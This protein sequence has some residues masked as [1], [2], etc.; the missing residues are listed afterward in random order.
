MVLYCGED[1]GCDDDDDDC[2]DDCC[3]DVT[4]EG[5][6]EKT[7]LDPKG[8][9]YAIKR[10]L[11]KYGFFDSLT[12]SAEDKKRSE[13]YVSDK[14]RQTLSENAS[15]LE[16][17]LRSL[18]LVAEIGDPSDEFIPRVS[19][20]T[21]KTNQFNLT[22]RRYSE[23]DIKNFLDSDRHEVYY[24]RLT[25]K[26]SDL[27]IIG[28]AI[29][30]FEEN[31]AEIDT[32]LMS[33]RA[34][35]R[36]AEDALMHHIHSQC[37]KRGCKSIIGRYFETA[38]NKQVSNFYEKQGFRKI[39]DKTKDNF[40]YDLQGFGSRAFPDWIALKSCENKNTVN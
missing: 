18:E 3:T 25:D 10:G 39:D 31:R 4:G 27:G 5:F 34:L 7:G 13:M 15:S 30:A 20:L 12:Y 37:E 2:C 28:V 22:T 9:L 35:G 24:M 40:S 6:L 32:F 8:A 38:K 26:I 36:G 14:K 16:D 33:C 29:I 17:Y 19:Q 23:G 1:D 11:S 21:Q